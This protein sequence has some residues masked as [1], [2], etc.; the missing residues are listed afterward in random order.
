MLSGS[1]V[2]WDFYGSYIYRSPRLLFIWCLQQQQKTTVC[3]LSWSQLCRQCGGCVATDNIHWSWSILRYIFF[4]AVCVVFVHLLFDFYIVLSLA[5]VHAAHWRRGLKSFLFANAL[6]PTQDQ[7]GLK[8]WR[9]LR[10]VYLSYS[11]VYICKRWKQN[12]LQL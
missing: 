2:K 5:A 9:A 7:L 6:K 8:C 11:S 3:Q 10:L 4:A 12:W 1:L